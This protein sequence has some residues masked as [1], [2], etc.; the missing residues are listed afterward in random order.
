M[1]LGR[2]NT[3]GKVVVYILCLVYSA[4]SIATTTVSDSGGTTAAPTNPSVINLPNGG[5]IAAPKTPPPAPP[6]QNTINQGAN[7]GQQAENGGSGA[8]N[9]AGAALIAAGTPLLANPQTMPMGMA[10]IAMG[11]LALM[12]GGSDSGAAGQSGNSAATSAINNGSPSSVTTDGGGGPTSTTDNGLKAA[13]ATPA[14]Q[15]AQAALASVG[16]SITAAGV[17]SPN[18]TTTPLSSFSSP[19]AMSA[20]G[21]D[22]KQAAAVLAGIEKKLGVDSSGR[23]SGM[24]TAEGAGGGGASNQFG[25]EL[26]FKMPKFGNPFDLSAAEKAQMLAGKTVTL[27]G[28][29]VGVAGDDLFAMIHRAYVRKTTTEEFINGIGVGGEAPSV[30]VR[31]PASVIRKHK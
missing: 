27:G 15:A 3:L 9:A 16:A 18:G 29:P 22:G 30:S 8:N 14:G 19:S 6:S 24:A 20:A 25:K 21:L 4:A 26:D 5:T 28:D 11:I 31:A 10:L 23:V 2:Q 7:T 13:F 1:T 12:Q 17:T